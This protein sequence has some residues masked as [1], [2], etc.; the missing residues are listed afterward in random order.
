MASGQHM[1]ETGRRLAALYLVNPTVDN[2]ATNRLAKS[3][4]AAL[5]GGRR[6]AV[7]VRRYLGRRDLH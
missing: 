6:A 2:P 1:T 4:A 3:I 5:A 7:L